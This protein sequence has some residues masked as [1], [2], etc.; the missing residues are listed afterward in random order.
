MVPYKVIEQLAV[1]RTH[2]QHDLSLHP[3]V[4]D[5]ILSAIAIFHYTLH[6]RLGSGSTFLR[7]FRA[8]KLMSRP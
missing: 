3:T 2:C 7:K 6:P 4:V 8:R 5:P 1:S